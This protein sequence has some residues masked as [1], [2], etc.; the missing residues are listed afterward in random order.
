MEEVVLVLDF[1]G[2]WYLSGGRIWVRGEGRKS[3]LIGGIIGVKVF[4]MWV[5]FGY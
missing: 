2:R 4:E 3:F 5:S 1:E